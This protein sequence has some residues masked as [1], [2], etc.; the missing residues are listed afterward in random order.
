MVA[1]IYFQGQHA[2]IAVSL[3]E[4]LTGAGDGEVGWLYCCLTST[5]N[6]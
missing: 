5:V 2:N 1:M 6:I 4:N 3:E